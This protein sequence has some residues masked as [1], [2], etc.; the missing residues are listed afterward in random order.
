MISRSRKSP[1]IRSWLK[2][3]PSEKIDRVRSLEVLRLMKEGKSLTSASKSIGIKPK[4][5]K[6][7]LGKFIYKRRGKWRTKKIENNIQ[8]ELQIYERG[9][10]RSI[11][12]RNSKDA[13]LIGRYYNDVKRGLMTGDWKPLRKYKKYKIKDAK[14]RLHRLETN[15]SK[16]KEIELAKEEPEFFDIYRYG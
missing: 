13:S 11:I 16:I 14:D 15:P 12:V 10:V 7:T 8:R 1:K 2:L 9:K 6:R 5:V 3:S 4:S